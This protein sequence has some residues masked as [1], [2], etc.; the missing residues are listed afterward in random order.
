[1]LRCSSRTSS[2][3][4]AAFLFVSG[5]EKSCSSPMS[6]GVASGLSKA[7][8]RAQA[9]S[10][11]PWSTNSAFS[12]SCLKSSASVMHAG[13][14]AACS[15]SWASSI[16][17]SF[18]LAK[19]ST[20][21][22]LGTISTSSCF[23]PVSS[24]KVVRRADFSA[25]KENHPLRK[26][27]GGVLDVDGIRAQVA[28]QAEPLRAVLGRH[29]GQPTCHR[30]DVLGGH[31]G[32]V[33]DGSS[34]NLEALHLLLE[35]LVAQHAQEG[36]PPLPHRE[37]DRRR[38]ASRH[39]PSG[40]SHVEVA[41]VALATVPAQ[42]FERGL[43]LAHDPFDGLL[44]SNVCSADVEEPLASV[45]PRA[46]HCYSRHLLDV[47][48]PHDR[49]G[50]VALNMRRIR[51]GVAVIR[52]EIHPPVRCLPKRLPV[53]FRQKCGVGHRAQHELVVDVCA[54]LRAHSQHHLGGGVQLDLAPLQPFAKGGAAALLRVA[55]A[56]RLHD[57]WCSEVVD[58]IGHHDG[59]NVLVA[60]PSHGRFLGP[61][62]HE[63]LGAQDCRERLVVPVGGVE[64]GRPEAFGAELGPLV[65]RVGGVELLALAL[66]LVL[67]V[68]RDTHGDRGGED[69][70]EL[71]LRPCRLDGLL[72]LLPHRAF[73]Q[74]LLRHRR[75]RVLVPLVQHDVHHH[76]Q[77]G[78]GVRHPQHP[79]V[80]PVD[81]PALLGQVVVDEDDA[82]VGGGVG[83][84]LGLLPLRLLVLLARG[85]S[86]VVKARVVG[87]VHLADLLQHLVGTRHGFGLVILRLDRRRDPGWEGGLLE[88]LQPGVLLES[89]P[90]P[91][92]RL[93]LP[94]ELQPARHVAQKVGHW[95]A[96][97]GPPREWHPVRD[98]VIQVRNEASRAVI[99]RGRDV[100]VADV[101]VHCV[102]VL[103]GPIEPASHSVR[104]GI[105]REGTLQRV[106][107]EGPGERT[108]GQIRR[109]LLDVVEERGH[110]GLHAL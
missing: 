104:L 79:A 27:G 16:I 31:A 23:S 94:D 43:H 89:R 1:M 65:V 83:G 18:G 93:E 99:N 57:G 55:L 101:G 78:E 41:D 90:V 71:E 103:R 26:A 81:H 59:G 109:D 46:H 36:E 88:R 42:L 37:V 39:V 32:C 28:P 91:F 60:V 92:E 34:E 6:G 15:P 86:L 64:H 50:A 45:G 100:Y 56:R 68:A 80:H 7:V 67:Q 98:N 44:P 30:K 21:G 76:P 29:H 40:A 12:P 82:R 95:A 22:M 62:L 38:H 2:E 70:A 97:L 54:I 58:V 49:R 77:G 106:P 85:G 87:G 5:H 51:R 110:V 10:P 19:A 33:E 69:D 102:L 13:V 63:M 75:R 20:K 74:A 25:A 107:H 14:F 105:R 35:V 47:R 72:V 66:R 53:L 52:T 108:R 24:P 3:T 96:V 9:C 84:D 8:S 4:C 11:M 48:E 73:V 17:R 61:L